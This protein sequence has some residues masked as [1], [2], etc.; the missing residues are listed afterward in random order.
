M[1]LFRRRISTDA[2]TRVIKEAAEGQP[3]SISL[4]EEQAEAILSQWQG[5]PERPARIVFRVKDRPRIEIPV[6]SCAYWSDTCCARGLR[7]IDRGDP[8]PDR[9]A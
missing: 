1:G 4:T 7:Y 3:I 8:P 6:A 2:A 9:P 5:D